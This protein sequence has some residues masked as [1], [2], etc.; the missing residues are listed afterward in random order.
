MKKITMILGIIGTLGVSTYADANDQ[1]DGMDHMMMHQQMMDSSTD[2]RIS[3]H[4]APQMKQGQLRNMRSHVEAIRD[5]VGLI[6]ENKLDEASRIAHQ[7]LGLT[8]EMKKMC[9]MFGNDDFRKLGLAFHQ[10]ADTLGDVLKTGD[11]QASLRA[12]HTTMNSCVQCHATFR[13]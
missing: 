9:G 3:L 2:K 1:M 11:V 8:P 13:Q 10:S 6:S 5:I 7:K 4:I 12:L